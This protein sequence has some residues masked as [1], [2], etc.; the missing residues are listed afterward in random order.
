MIDVKTIPA[1]QLQFETP[2]PL[3]VIAMIVLC[4]TIDYL[5]NT[6]QRA[7]LCCRT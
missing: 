5:T 1:T 3:Q 2:H 6:Q 7:A 4:N